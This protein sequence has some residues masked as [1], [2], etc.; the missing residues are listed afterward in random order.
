MDE[1]ECEADSFIERFI[2]E[3][4]EVSKELGPGF[5]FPEMIDSFIR[6]SESE[7]MDREEIAETE[8]LKFVR[9]LHQMNSMLMLYGRYVD[10]LDPLIRD[11]AGNSQKPVRLLELACGSGG[12]AFSIAEHAVRNKLNLHVT[13]SDIVPEFVREGTRLAAQRS[14]PVKFRQINAFDMQH[15]H[16]DDFDIMVVSQSL[17]HFTPGQL[18]RIIAQSAKHNT[19][20][21]IGIDGHRSILLLGGVPLVASLQGIAPFTQDG[22]T[23]ARRFYSDLE[24]DIITQ[25][26]TGNTHHRVECAWPLTILTI[27][28][29]GR[30]P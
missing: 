17:H 11:I 1:L 23:S 7:N 20:S 2:A 22:L 14:L 29:D 3:R 15:F 21:F 13:A 25:I 10:I 24:L 9:A 12:L 16:E 18:A 4:H 19:T 6:T 27:R 28:F 8:K 5:L 30:K 26:A